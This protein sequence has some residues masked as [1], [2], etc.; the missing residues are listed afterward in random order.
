VSDLALAPAVGQAKTICCAP[1][2]PIRG[3][4][5][6]APSSAAARQDVPECE[7]DDDD[8]CR[9]G[10]DGDGGSGKDHAVRF[11]VAIGTRADEGETELRRRQ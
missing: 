4:G 11:P 5:S 10:D 3:A 9:D 2:P 8:C 7:G 1:L 6:L